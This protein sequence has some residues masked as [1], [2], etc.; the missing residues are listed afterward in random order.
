[1]DKKEI[2]QKCLINLALRSGFKSFEEFRINSENKCKN[3]EYVAVFPDFQIISTTDD[4]V[5]V[6]NLKI[7]TAQNL[8]DAKTGNII[9]LTD[10]LSKQL[11]INEPPIGWWASEKWD[12]IR[13]L[14]DGEKIISRG[15]GLG[16]PKVYTYIPEWFK[17][18]LPPGIA[19]DG[20]IWIGRGYFQK[21]SRLS[22]LKPGKSYTQKQIDDIWSGKEDPPVIFKV[23]DIPSYDSNFEVRMTKLKNVINERKIC[24]NK[25]S[26]ENKKVFPLHFTEQ[27]KIETPEQLYSLYKKL[28]GEGAEGIMLRA[29]GSPYELKR[30]KYML[31]Y[32]IKEDA[33]CIVLDYIMGEGRL[34]GMLGSIKCE[35]L[36]DKG[37][38]SGIITQIGTGFTDLQRENY[39][40]RESSEY[41]PIGSVVSFSFMEMTK[42]GL[43]RHPVYR[44][45]RDDIKN[46]NQRVTV[47]TVKDIL[48]KIMN[49]T[50][51]DKEQNWQFKIKFYKQAIDILDETKNLITV[52]DYINS[53]REGGMLLKDEENFK[54]KTG[55]WKS[56]IIQ[57]ID[58]ILKD[59][60]IDGISD[61][62]ENI[63]IENLTKIAGIGPSNASKIYK[64]EGITNIDELREVHKIN[65]SILN[66]KQAIGLVH[67]EDLQKRIPRSEMDLWKR[68][69]EDTFQEIQSKEEIDGILEITGSYRRK[70]KDSG[71]I[72]V[73]IST[74]ENNTNLIDKFYKLLVKD[75][76]IEKEN[77]IAKG[78]TKIMAVAKIDDTYRHLDIFY[79]PK[80][81]YPF[82]LLFTT[83]SKELNT[84]MRAHAL[85]MGY[86]LNERNL[87]IKTPGGREVSSEEY[88]N[89]IGKFKPETE[90]DIFKFLDYKYILPE[91]R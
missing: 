63:A 1:M 38:K 18:I 65:K 90:E 62:L 10:K 67:Y 34:K 13:A 11:N 26:Y 37:E 9:K 36:N 31:K 60:K 76:I 53:L 55:T 85:K 82:A 57:K 15:S 4:K 61:D 74:K 22:T 49:K 7:M 91:N 28:T 70:N 33:E 12:G 69:L 20:E 75:S 40:N 24:W 46:P 68:I 43:P 14:W 19:L 29:P 89:K 64:E 5:Y 17:N 30:S 25:I 23:F 52:Q 58:T 39:S 80:E 50:Q 79:Y 16:K 6:D 54:T 44:G 56:A 59:G 32:K 35:L 88:F 2:L 86:S 81:V 71:D 3:K 21:T 72:D 47:K 51:K 41:I 66:S 42:D 77:T 48:I 8:Y 87:T 78:P 83:G 84:N 27:I 73:L 45:I